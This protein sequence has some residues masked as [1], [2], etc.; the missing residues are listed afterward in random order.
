MMHRIRI[1]SGE[2]RGHYISFFD[3]NRYSGIIHSQQ[4]E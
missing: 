2:Y 1:T 4:I 3:P